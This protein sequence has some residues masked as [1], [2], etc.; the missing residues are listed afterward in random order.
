MLSTEFCESSIK[1]LKLAI[2]VENDLDYFYGKSKREIVN[3]LTDYLKR[4]DRVNLPSK[5]LQ[6]KSKSLA[7]YTRL[8]ESGWMPTRAEIETFAEEIQQYEENFP[9]EM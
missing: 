3:E 1:I 8:I 9:E 2:V 5:E 4:I 7:E 6:A